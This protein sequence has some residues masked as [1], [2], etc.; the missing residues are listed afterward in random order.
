MRKF[1]S[2]LCVFFVTISSFADISSTEKQSLIDL[3]H[4]T[5]GSQWNNSWDLNTDV[6][7]WHG[8]TLENNA[9]V[10]LQLRFNNLEGTIPKS[11]KNLTNLRS[12]ELSFNKLNGVIPSEIG[13]LSKLE[14]F[15]VNGNNLTGIIPLSIGN[16]IFL[17]EF[18]VSSNKLTGILPNE[19]SN[20]LKLEV[21][22]V[23]D[24]SLSGDIP[25][26]LVNC[27]NLKQLLVAKNNF[28]PS[29]LFS[30]VQLSAT[31]TEIDFSDSKAK[32]Q[33]ITGTGGGKN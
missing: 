12:L 19:I 2:L 10:S 32:G 31:G 27:K 5:N 28:N 14:T 33:A 16:L 8:V 22:N 24:N 30:A 29:I 17:K 20:L 7:T 9:V 15:A 1:L 11:I 18:H 13:L 21:L 4:S 26:S 25:I 3:Y 6:S 23:F